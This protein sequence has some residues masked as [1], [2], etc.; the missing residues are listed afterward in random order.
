MTKTTNPVIIAHNARVAASNTVPTA[1][2]AVSVGTKAKRII[3]TAVT[4]VVLASGIASITGGATDTET[5][6][7]VSGTQVGTVQQAITH[8]NGDLSSR[9]LQQAYRLFRELNNVQHGTDINMI[10][11]GEYIIPVLN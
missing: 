4:A 8:V 6:T 10:Q 1:V 5:I 3:L 11:A 9:E 7:I 2:V